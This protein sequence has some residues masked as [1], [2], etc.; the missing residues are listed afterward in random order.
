M[1]EATTRRYDRH[2]LRY[3]KWWGP[4]IAPAA[5]ALFERV[6]DALSDRPPSRVLDVGT[7]TGVL[8]RAAVRR[9][10]HAR[11]V[12]LDGSAGMLGVAEAGA[13]GLREDEAARLSWSTGLAER[14]PFPDGDFELVISSFVFQ[15]VPDRGL[16]LR[17]AFRVLRP[18]GLLGYVT[19]LAAEDDYAPQR[20]F[21]DIVDEEGLEDGRDVDDGRSGDVPSVAAAA[22]QLRRAG[23]RD[24]RAGEELLEHG[25]SATEYL[26]F[27]ERYDAAELFDSLGRAGRSRLRRLTAERLADLA[28]ADLLWRA[29]LISALATKPAS[30]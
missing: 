19:W 28:P 23:F 18:G 2:A 27:L 12:G 25:W 6:A 3:E 11:V 22:A 29:P 24:V 16:A 10:R 15:L 21:D 5:L 26:R 4:V 13:R 30:T 8:A 20:I 14:L 1:S 17:E 9:W 7:G